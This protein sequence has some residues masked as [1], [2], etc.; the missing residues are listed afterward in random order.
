MGLFY[1]SGFMPAVFDS[2]ARNRNYI[3]NLIALP[4]EPFDHN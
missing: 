2:V 1:Y 4:K 3:H